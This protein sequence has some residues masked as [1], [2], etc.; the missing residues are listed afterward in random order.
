MRF[1]PLVLALSLLGV[2]PACGPSQDSR[3]PTDPTSGLPL[4]LGHAADVF[5]DNIDPTA[6]GLSMEG[7]SPRSDRF[8]RERAQTAEIVAR[9][10]V[11]TVTADSVGDST[12][13]HLGILVG[14][15]T[16]AKPRIP[17]LSFEVVI[18]PSSKAYSIAR[19]LESSLQGRTF[20]G[21]FHRY[22]SDDGEQVMH[23]HLA[24]DTPDVAAAVKEAVALGEI[25]G[26]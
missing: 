3:M 9:V 26:S 15:P 11:Q 6:M 18:K 14:V 22:A 19:Q 13:Y 25:S 1:R 23:F 2:L 4:W 12:T 24:P 8:L 20:I 7:P 16:L 21:F 17:D 5:D 10:K